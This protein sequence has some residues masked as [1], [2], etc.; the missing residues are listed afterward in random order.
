MPIGWKKAISN[1][2]LTKEPPAP[3]PHD[4]SQTLAYLV[5]NL[6]VKTN[7]THKFDVHEEAF[8]RVV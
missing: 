6:A 3:P 7:P 8:W 5:V 4:D 1:L 2:A